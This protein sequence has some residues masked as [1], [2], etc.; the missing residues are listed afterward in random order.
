MFRFISL[1]TRFA[2]AA[3]AS[4]ASIVGGGMTPKFARLCVNRGQSLSFK[5]RLKN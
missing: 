4:P 5:W 3:K 2:Q 1:L